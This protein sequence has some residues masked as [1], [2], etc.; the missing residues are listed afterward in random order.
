MLGLLVRHHRH[1][2][3]S[4][5]GPQPRHTRAG[6]DDDGRGLGGGGRRRGRGGRARGSGAQ[7]G[8]APLPWLAW[9]GRLRRVRRRHAHLHRGGDEYARAQAPALERG[10]G[11]RACS[12]HVGRAGDLRAPRT[13]PMA[14][15]APCTPSLAPACPTT[16]GM[17]G[18]QQFSSRRPAGLVACSSPTAAPAAYAPR[19][20]PC[21]PQLQDT[22]ERPAHQLAA[23]SRSDL[24]G[25]YSALVTTEMLRWALGRASCW[26]RTLSALAPPLSLLS[27]SSWPIKRESVTAVQ[28]SLGA[29]Q[30][31]LAQ[32]AGTL[33]PT[34]P[35]SGLC[36]VAPSNT[37]HQ[38]S[39]SFSPVSS[40]STPLLSPSPQHEDHP[41]L[42]GH[43]RSRGVCAP[44]V[45][46]AA[47]ANAR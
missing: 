27:I 41:S 32:P 19:L 4:H 29:A 7:G 15:I 23:R 44:Q 8:Q 3:G 9:P 28:P 47:A 37:P 43:A 33:S 34:Q 12:E 31:S 26:T 13:P 21:P 46:A 11:G 40:V 18:Q 42:C 35:H 10:R 45:P 39:Q 20:L 25:A 1:G 30:A 14:P 16:E 24:R 17:M 38:P 5:G 6:R 22:C 2:L 36:E